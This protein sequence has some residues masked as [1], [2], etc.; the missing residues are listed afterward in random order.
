M[1]SRFELPDHSEYLYEAS[2]L[3]GCASSIFFWIRFISR[4]F[5]FYCIFA[6]LSDYG[7]WDG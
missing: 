3:F 1:Y 4:C 7:D 5:S 6:D 2:L